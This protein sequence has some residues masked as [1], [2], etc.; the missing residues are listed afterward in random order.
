MSADKE[1]KKQSNLPPLSVS[2]RFLCDA[3]GLEKDDSRK[4]KMYDENWNEQEGLNM[5]EDCFRD[6]LGVS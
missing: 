4:H 3:C 1:I 6:G 2:T 5:C